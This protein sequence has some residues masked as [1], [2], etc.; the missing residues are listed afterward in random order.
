MK[1]IIHLVVAICLVLVTLLSA[2]P[3]SAG[4]KT[5]VTGW[6]VGIDI[7][8]NPDFREWM[9][10][11]I[12]HWR[13]ETL[14]Y[15]VFASDPRL[16]GFDLSSNNGDIH[17]SN[18]GDPLFMHIYAQGIIYKNENFT[19][20]LWSCMSNGGID[21]QWY[22]SMETECHGT[23]ENAGLVAH[24]SFTSSEHDIDFEGEILAP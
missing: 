10:D 7:E 6:M 23:S 11:H 19:V 5:G 1:K 21:A 8:Q 12:W 9:S 18:N 2:F 13:N 22:F 17:L 14:A 16:N 24:L 15:Q 20:P 4:T 3:A